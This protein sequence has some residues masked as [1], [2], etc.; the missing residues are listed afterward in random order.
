M[1]ASRPL[2]LSQVRTILLPQQYR[3]VDFFF[4]FLS[5]TTLFHYRILGTFAAGVQSGIGN[6]T[7]GSSF[8]TAQAIAMGAPIPA[9]IPIVGGTILA[10]VGW[11]TV[12]LT[13]KAVGSFSRFASGPP[14]IGGEAS[15]GGGKE[16]PD[17]E[18]AVLVERVRTTM[19]QERPTGKS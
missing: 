18:S 7:A 8:A 1:P 19:D 13:R 10:A 12:W 15:P 9:I 6:V 16:C 11:A 14:S 4:S 5:P 3:L 2:A 17:P